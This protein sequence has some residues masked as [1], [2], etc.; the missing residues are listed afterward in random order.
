MIVDFTTLTRRCFLATAFTVLASAAT[1]ASAA[2][3][4]DL[5]DPA[6]VFFLNG[7]AACTGVNPGHTAAGDTS[8][9]T[10]CASLQYMHFL[11]PEFNPATHTLDSAL[12][13]L[14]FRDDETGIPESYSLSLDGMSAGSQTIASGSGTLSNFSYDVKVQMELDGA[15]T[16]NLVRAGTNPNSDFWFLQS[17]VDADYSL[18]TSSA[19]TVVTPE[20]ASLLLVG[21]GLAAVG[22][23]LRRRKQKSM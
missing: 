7:G 3:I 1:P 17:T 19:P 15:L 22:A 6:D 4:T 9:S 20:P 8:S 14:F 11:T 12:L 18:K 2:S 23:R 10:N 5:Y 21:G 13:T 16:V